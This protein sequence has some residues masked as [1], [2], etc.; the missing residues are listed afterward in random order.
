[1]TIP[2]GDAPPV[3]VLSTDEEI[4]AAII[5]ARERLPEFVKALAQPN[6][7]QSHFAVKYPFT[8]KE[9][10]EVEHLWIINLTAK[11]DK[12]LGVV[13]NDP[14]SIGDLRYG[15]EVEIPQ[16]GITDWIYFEN[17]VQIGAFSKKVLMKRTTPE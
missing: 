3:P 8:D 9:S 1:M 12:F 15:Q 16:A 13:G 4:V 2:S 14:V 11:G 10:E 5:E 6:A 7:T 17:G